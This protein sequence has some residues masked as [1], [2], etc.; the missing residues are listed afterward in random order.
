MSSNPPTPERVAVIVAAAGES[1]R[2]A[3]IDKIFTPLQGKPLL[4]HSVDIFERSPAV[5][6]IVLVLRSDLHPQA[7]LLV[8]QQ[9]WTKVIGIAGGG[10]RRQDSVRNGLALLSN[11]DW[12]AVHDGARPCLDAAILS[13]GLAAV[14]ETGAAIAAIPAKDTIKVVG[15]GNLVESTP[16]RETLWQVQTPQ[17]FRASLLR[18]AYASLTSDVTDDAM[19]VERLGHKIKVF[20]GSYENLKVTTP[21]DL[22]VASVFLARRSSAIPALSRSLPHFDGEEPALQQR[23]EGQDGVPSP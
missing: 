10:A 13:R 8:R 3:G 22:T 19:L 20:M 14:R 17:I 2:M 11:V 5:V 1:R 12:I 4:A 6:S 18:A 16:N 21:E 9:G 7:Q 23:G 15:A